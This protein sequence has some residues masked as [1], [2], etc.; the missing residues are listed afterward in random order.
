MAKSETSAECTGTP[1]FSFFGTHPGIHRD[2]PIRHRLGP[3]VSPRRERRGIPLRTKLC[4][5]VRR[6]LDLGLRQA[7]HDRR[8]CPHR[9]GFGDFHYHPWQADEVNRPESAGVTVNRGAAPSR[10]LVQVMRSHVAF[11]SAKVWER[12]HFRGAKGDITPHDIVPIRFFQHPFRLRWSSSGA[13]PC[14]LSTF[15]H[16][17]Y[18]VAILPTLP[19]GSKGGVTHSVGT[20]FYVATVALPDVVTV[21]G[22]RNRRILAPSN[23]PPKIVAAPIPYAKSAFRGIKGN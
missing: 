3:R 17:A 15:D 9:R 12:A 1:L 2:T 21:L 11:R 18:L 13:S 7:E 5:R 10:R 19:I 22:V 6:P 14:H 20:I 23:R 16:P 8:R 4:R